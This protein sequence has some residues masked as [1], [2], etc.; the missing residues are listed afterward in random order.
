MRV[1]FDGVL[2]RGVTAKDMVLALIGRLGA[3]GGAG[4]VVEYAGSAVR[5]PCRSRAA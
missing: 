5:G 4:H 3:A 1:H 2:P